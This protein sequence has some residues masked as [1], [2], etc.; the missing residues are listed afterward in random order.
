MQAPHAALSCQTA[1]ILCLFQFLP[2][3]YAPS[4]PSELRASTRRKKMMPATTGMPTVLHC[5]MLRNQCCPVPAALLEHLAL[6]A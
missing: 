1:A 2:E 6:L 3:Q 5:V 4:G